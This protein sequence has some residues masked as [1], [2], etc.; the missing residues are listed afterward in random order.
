MTFTTQRDGQTGYIVHI[1][2]GEGDRVKDCRSLARFE[3]KG[4]PP[5]K[6]GEARLSVSFRIDAD[7]LLAVRAQ[8]TSSGV[9]QEIMVNPSYGL[10]EV[11]IKKL[12]N[13]Q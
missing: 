2:Q 1:L 8:E 13:L 4:I 5:M 12:L 11:K 6:S 9:A 3:L 10:E 7:G